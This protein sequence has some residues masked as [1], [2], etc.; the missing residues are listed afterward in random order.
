ML[1]K[2]EEMPKK[3]ATRFVQHATQVLGNRNETEIMKNNLFFIVS[4]NSKVGFAYFF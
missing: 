2:R 3:K 4:M 1:N